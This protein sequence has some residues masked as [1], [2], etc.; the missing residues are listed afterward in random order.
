MAELAVSVSTFVF[1]R[2]VVIILALVRS[3]TYVVQDK[4]LSRVDPSKIL[5]PA[6]SWEICSGEWGHLYFGLL[7]NDADMHPMLSQRQHLLKPFLIKQRIISEIWSSQRK[8]NTQ[9][10]MFSAFELRYRG[11][12]RSCSRGTFCPRSPELT[13]IS[14]SSRPCPRARM[15]PRHHL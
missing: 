10:R 13:T 11:T 8:T 4:R 15:T 6:G 3:T 1:P 9:L 5:R 14:C 12:N 2:R 7:E